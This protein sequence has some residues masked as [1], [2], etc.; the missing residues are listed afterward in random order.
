MKIILASQSP[1][2]QELLKRIVDEFTVLAA[3][4]NEE[5]PKGM[6]P[7]QYVETMAEK[8]ARYI[9]QE[10][11]ETLV[12]GCDTIVT[13]DDEII[14]K[15]VS[16]EHGFQVLRKLSGRKHLV[17]TSVFIMADNHV[18][19][20]L[21]PAEVVFYDLSDEEI[22]RYLDVDEYKDKAGAYGIQ[23]Q[24]ALF[25]KEIKGDYYSIMGLPIAGLAR[26]LET[27]FNYRKE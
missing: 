6:T 18:S 9:T 3:D 4:I 12:I 7:V 10:N 21:V 26:L 16:R 5:V 23:E 2:R 27:E 24:G 25:V 15:P 19:S 1:R 22:N 20:L 8:K 13:I 14:G 17:Y 11:P